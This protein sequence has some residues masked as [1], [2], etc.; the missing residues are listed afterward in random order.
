[1][2]GGRD[3]GFGFYIFVAFNTRVTRA[4]DYFSLLREDFKSR[5][6]NL[7]PPLEDTGLS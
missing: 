1:M 4:L 5:H 7:L 2:K 3:N 6:I